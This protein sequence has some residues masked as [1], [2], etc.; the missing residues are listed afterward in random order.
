M[1]DTDVERLVDTCRV[2]RDEMRLDEWS[3]SRR[4]AREGV[5]LPVTEV[6]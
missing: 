2:A 3:A 4:A 5:P 6:A 1:S